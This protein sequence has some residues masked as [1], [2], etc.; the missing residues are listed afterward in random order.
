MKAE[1]KLVCGWLV[2]IVLL[3]GCVPGSGN[4]LK[5]KLRI[6]AEQDIHMY[7]AQGLRDFKELHPQVEIEFINVRNLV[8]DPLDMYANYEELVVEQQPDVVI[9]SELTFPMLTEEARLLPLESKAVQDELPIEEVVPAVM[10]WLRDNGHGQLYGLVPSFSRNLIF[11][12]TDLFDEHG[13]MYP[14]DQM[15]WQELLALAQ[16][17]PDRSEEGERLFG[18]HDGLQGEADYLITSI[19]STRGLSYLDWER[20]EITLA[21]EGW[22]QV[23]ELAVNALRSG[24]IYD[25]EQHT[26]TETVTDNSHNPVN[27][28]LDGRVAMMQGDTHTFSTL[29]SQAPEVPWAMVTEPVDPLNRSQAEMYVHD[30][31]AIYETSANVDAAW[32]LVKHMNN[33][34]VQSSD[35]G[36]GISAWTGTWKALS[37]RDEELA[38]VWS[39]LDYRQ[40]SPLPFWEIPPGFLTAVTEIRHNALVKMLSGEATVEE[41]L[42]QMDEQGQAALDQSQLP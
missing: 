39:L 40:H 25:Q 34:P 1:M 38:E 20:R 2:L 24:S 3:G 21:S 37:G 35:D 42:Q 19:A 12:R 11:F 31:Y 41:A 10:G 15:S 18:F 32:A 5:G 17:F 23:Y 6:V 16:Q 4:S 33:R 8:D 13:V 22:R 27:L 30:V 26:E 9:A 14:E 28:F 36:K 7:H 29:A